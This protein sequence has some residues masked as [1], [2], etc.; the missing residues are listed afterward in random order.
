MKGSS[1]LAFKLCY[2]QSPW[3]H[4]EAWRQLL[5]QATSPHPQE[6]P[7][8]LEMLQSAAFREVGARGKHAVLVMCLFDSS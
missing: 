8:I 7:S 2:E 3:Y 5:V 4:D 6:R 1:T